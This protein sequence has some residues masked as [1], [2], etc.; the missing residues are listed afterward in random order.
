MVGTD[1]NYY[2]RAEWKL[3][4]QGHNMFLIEGKN[5]GRYVMVDETIRSGGEGGWSEAPAVLA[6]D[7]NYYGLALWKF[8]ES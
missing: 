7:E 6:A 4:P 3:I 2:D 1:A 8:V 5:S